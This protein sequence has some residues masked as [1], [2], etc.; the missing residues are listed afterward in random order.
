MFEQIPIDP[1][2]QPHSQISMK[3]ANFQ[4]EISLLTSNIGYGIGLAESTNSSTVFLSEIV[5]RK[6]YF[7]PGLVHLK[8]S[9]RRVLL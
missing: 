4:R 3:S 1:S 6:L 8:Q 5:F 9:A 7:A 2:P